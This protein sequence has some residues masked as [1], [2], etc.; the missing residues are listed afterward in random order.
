MDDHTPAPGLSYNVR[1][2]TT[3]GGSEIVSAP[4]LANGKLLAPQMGRSRNGSAVLHELSSGQT[5]YWSVQA[6]DS[7]FAGSPFAPEQ[8]FNTGGL[9]INPIRRP[10]GILE[11][12]FNAAPGARFNVLATTNLTVRLSNWTLLGTATEISPGQFRFA[13]TQATNNP[14]RFYRVQ[15]L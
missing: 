6:V 10:D 1:V 11:L 7:G 4:A 12:N 2:G 8:Q 15:S 9:V 5:Y 3:P 13:D 14:R